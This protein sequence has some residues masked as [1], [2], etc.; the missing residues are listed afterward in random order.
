[1][2][3]EYT[4]QTFDGINLYGKT[5]AVAKPR[6]AVVIV[7]GLCEHQGRYDYL[8]MRLNAQGYSVYRFD[9]RGHGKSEGTKVYYSAY[10]EIAKDTDVVVDRALSENPDIPVFML[11]H[12]MGGYGAA[13][14][15]HLHPKKVAGYVLSGA[16]TRDNG[17]LGQNVIEQCKDMDDLDY[18]PNQLGDGVCS[19]PSVGER[20]MAD[21]LVMK[22][23]SVGLF[24]ALHNGHVFMRENPQ[25]FVDPVL[26][27][28]GGADGLVS[29][30]DSL[31]LFDTIASKDKS[32]R[33]YSGL[34]HEIFNEY[35][36]DAVIADALAWLNA[37]APQVR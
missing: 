23:M 3:E 19:D 9:H 12:S 11:G 15:G 21:P 18:V 17:K 13:L 20:Y 24:R 16:W 27:L 30:K 28:H 1:M 14:Y 31:E 29:P 7:H 4:F 10:D 5:D 22:Q 34:M 37:R 25:L 6:A 32:L 33:I 8:T 35:D 26:I 2:A 36:K